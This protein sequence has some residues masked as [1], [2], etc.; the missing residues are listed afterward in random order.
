MAANSKDF[1][2]N[3]ACIVFNGRKDVLSN[4][5]PCPIYYNEKWFNCAEQAYQY[6]KAIYHDRADLATTIMKLKSG[7]RQKLCG[8]IIE[9]DPKWCENAG[10]YYMKRILM[11]KLDCVSEYKKLLLNSTGI[12]IAAVPGDQYWSCGLN[13]AIIYSS[14]TPEWTGRNLLGKIHMELRYE[15]QFTRNILATSRNGMVDALV[16]HKPR[17]SIADF[18][19]DLENNWVTVYAKDL[20][21]AHAFTDS[22]SIP[23]KAVRVMIGLQIY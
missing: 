11:A 20:D 3:S 17:N 9:N 10:V 4:L 2:R 13:K 16:R 14:K 21:I 19:I 7:H 6:E 1:I 23:R 8:Q 22:F 12:L 18:E 5:Y 15:L